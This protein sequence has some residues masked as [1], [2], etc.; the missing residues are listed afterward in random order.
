MNKEYDVYTTSNL[1]IRNGIVSA[2]SLLGAISM[3]WHLFT[4]ESKQSKA[5]AAMLAFGASVAGIVAGNTSRELLDIRSTY[6]DISRIARANNLYAEMTQSQQALPPQPFQPFDWTLFKTQPNEY[7]HA[8]LLGASGDGKSTLAEN[9]SGLMQPSTV[10]A[11]VP[12]W[13]SGEFSVCDRVLAVGRN[14]GDGFDGDPTMVQPL[15]T[16]QDIEG[17][18]AEAPVSA[19][20][21]LHALYWEMH[22]RYQ[23]DPS[24]RF[25]GGAGKE[26]VVIL[27][28]FLLYAKLPGV[29]SLWKKLVREARKVKIRLILLVQGDSV[30]ALGIEGEGDIRENLTYIY[31]KQFAVQH[32][33]QCYNKSSSDRIPYYQWVREQFQT[34]RPC[35]VEDELAI[36]PN[37]GQYNE[38]SKQIPTPSHAT[39]SGRPTDVQPEDSGAPV[40]VPV[41]TIIEAQPPQA[42]VPSAQQN[43]G[44]FLEGYEEITASLTPQQLESSLRGLW[45]TAKAAASENMPSGNPYTREAIIKKIWG[46]ESSQYKIG[47][48]L[49]VLAQ[50]RYGKITLRE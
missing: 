17:L 6:R 41:T 37:P 27:D 44:D 3:T 21:L 43:S 22:R 25:L 4:V 48:V 36:L 28:E 19:C 20:E 7:P 34:H 12:H 49:W 47:K 30:A 15:Y 39:L 42:P 8:L 24:G 9:L 13:Q 46:Y 33:D 26:I 1:A 45:D 31:L 40:H 23:L 18:P 11:V 38:N 50:D 5:G 14:V 32:L 16:W 2:L 29:A 35:M 10:Y